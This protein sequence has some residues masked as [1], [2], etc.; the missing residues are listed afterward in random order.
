[1]HFTRREFVRIG[2]LAAAGAPF[3]RFRHSV[4]DDLPRLFFGADDVEQIRRNARSRL[5]SPLL[6]EW[7]SIP[8]AEDEA[9]ITKVLDTGD[10]LYDWGVGLLSIY[11]QATLALITDEKRHRDL[12]MTG[13][14]TLRALPRWDYLLDGG[15]HPL[16]L[17][18]ASKAVTAALLSLEV[19]G[20]DVPMDFRK[21]LLA[22][23]AEKGCAPCHLT[24][25]QMNHPEEA[26]GW[27]V[28][29]V[30]SAVVT[31][32][33]SRFPSILGANNLRAIPTMGLGLGAL[34]LAGRDPRAEMWRDAAVDSAR[35]F[36]G[37]FEPDGSYFEGISYIDFAF[38]TLFLF[39]EADYRIRG[40]VDWINEAN[41]DGI[42][43]YIAALQNGLN[44]DGTPDV[45]NFSD[46]HDTVYTCVPS[47]IANRS[48]NPVAA[49]AAQHFARTGYF[50]DFL[51]YH[52][53]REGEPP[54]DSLKNVRLDLGWIVART[55]W[56]ANDTVLAFRSGGPMNH[57]H[58]DRNTFIL[59]SKG[60]R[61]LTDPF[62]AS[63][64]PKDPK[65][66]LR[67]PIA[68]NSVLVDGRG[69]QYHHGEE[70]TNASLA[71]AS[72]LAYEDR[73]DTVYWT[74]DATTAY[75]L[76]D[77]RIT[78]VHRSM[79]F[80]KPDLVIMLDEVEAL[81]SVSAEILFHPDNRDGGVRLEVINDTEFAIH[82]PKAVLRGRCYSHTPVRLEQ[83]ALDL[84]ED[85]GA[86]PYL[87]AV[88]EKESSIA[89]LTVLE[90]DP[91]QAAE[92]TAT[93]AG[94]AIVRGGAAI[95]TVEVVEG[96][97]VMRVEK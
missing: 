91:E 45:V 55:G 69:H 93:D 8:D 16:G 19:L 47:W 79:I 25:Q 4:S 85:A 54:P 92:V 2:A 64:N 67:L 73:G 40:D 46:A 14:R 27:G 63:Y 82:R 30:Q 87:D 71:L 33:M 17:M 76:V 36:F 81:E 51:W 18:R 53:E 29:E 38:R 10:L 7:R 34:A 26:E 1:M 21:R 48:D 70:G 39:L 61:L 68:H 89:V 60:E 59:K 9:T 86:F 11:R 66:L 23:V 95:A 56:N 84:P 83:K 35:R 58:A 42:V 13:L 41:F 96:L 49:Y 88:S 32:D 20:S 75:Q 94:W 80:H 28:D 12:T 6:D 31:V 5:L 24:I 52:P 37:L 50:A 57:E 15:T 72:I 77:S 90:I 65:W 74:S 22:D 44:A 62:G 97:P 3:Y 78:L 43:D